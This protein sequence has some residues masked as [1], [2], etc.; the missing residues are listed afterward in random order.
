MRLDVDALQRRFTFTPCVV[1]HENTDE[2]SGLEKGFVCEECH[3]AVMGVV[4]GGASF[5]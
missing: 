5:P 3:D 1:V 4:R 2:R